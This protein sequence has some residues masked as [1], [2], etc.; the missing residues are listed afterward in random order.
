MIAT[1]LPSP[2][3]GTAYSSAT[4]HSYRLAYAAKPLVAEVIVRRQPI[5]GYVLA[6]IFVASVFTARDV[7]VFGHGY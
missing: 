5:E 1:F 4:A 2:K 6:F 7:T 3:M